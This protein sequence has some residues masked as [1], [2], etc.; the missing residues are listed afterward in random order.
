[1]ECFT[2]DFLQFF[3]EKRQKFSFSVDG[4]VLVI[5]SK[6]FRDFLEIFEFPKI[7]SLFF[8]CEHIGPPSGENAVGIKSQVVWKFVRQLVYSLSGDNN[9]VPFHLW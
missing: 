8:L 1:M 5:K 3:T 2:A 9:L 6:H 4:W 7:L